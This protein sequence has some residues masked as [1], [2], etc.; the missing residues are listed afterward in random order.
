[1]GHDALAFR[2]RLRIDVDDRVRKNSLRDVIKNARLE[3]LNAREHQRRLVSNWLSCGRHS[4]ETRNQPPV[5][6]GQAAP[7]WCGLQ[8]TATDARQIPQPESFLSSKPF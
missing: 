6:P 3:D 7:V 2:E 8:S 5:F 4:G 1:M